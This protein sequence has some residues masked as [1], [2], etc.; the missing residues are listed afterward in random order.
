MRPLRSKGWPGVGVLVG[1]PSL[2]G[3]AVDPAPVE[4]DAARGRLG[5]GGAPGGGAYRGCCPEDGGGPG[6]GAYRGCCGDEAKGG[7]G[8][9]SDNWESGRSGNDPGGPGDGYAMAGGGG[10]PNGS[11]A[12]WKGLRGPCSTTVSPPPMSGVRE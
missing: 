9:L 10:S 1:Y 6:G 2:E 7:G 3:G 4:V 5:G 12:R 11:G 8:P